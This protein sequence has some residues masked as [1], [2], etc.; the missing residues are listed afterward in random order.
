MKIY[1]FEVGIEPKILER[2][3]KYFYDG[4]VVDLWSEKSGRFCAV[5]DGSIPYDVEIHLDEDFEIVYHDC[6]CPYDWSEY[7][8]HEVAVLLAIREHF[9]RKTTLKTHGKKR[10]LRSRLS[11]IEKD[12]LISILCNLASECDLWYE[13]VRYLDETD[14]E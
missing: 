3:K 8:K 6:D 4:L 10:G 14:D 7:C 11:E 1:Y 9:E 2:G 12:D 5:V 13:I